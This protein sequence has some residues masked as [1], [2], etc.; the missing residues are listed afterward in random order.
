MPGPFSIS[1]SSSLVTID[2]S[3]RQS[4]IAFTVTNTLSRRLR[5]TAQIDVP[6]GSPA[7]AW[8]TILQPGGQN[9]A[10]ELPGTLRSYDLGAT[11]NYQVKVAVPASAAPGSYTFRLIVADE[12]NPDDLFTESADVSIV[13]KSI[14]PITRC[15]SSTRMKT[16]TAT[17]MH[18]R[19]K[20]SL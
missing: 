12:N 2:D 11:E 1:S 5:A 18:A 9:E 15:S 7:G 17:I 16:F 19:I 14:A 4:T 6:T 8:V 13:V 20:S 10:P 3:K